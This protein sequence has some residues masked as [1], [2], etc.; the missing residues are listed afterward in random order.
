MEVD[1]TGDSTG[2]VGETRIAVHPLAIVHMS[3]Q[4][5]RIT[6]GGSP[7]DKTDPVVGLLFG[8]SEDQTTA[9]TGN[10]NNSNVHEGPL[11]QVLDAD[12]IPVE[13]SETSTM[14]VDLHKAVF[15][16]H[17]V[18][19]WYRAVAS[20]SDDE[21]IE[22]TSE[23]LGITKLL[24]NHYTSS[25]LES[26]CFCLLKVQKEN[27][28]DCQEPGDDAAM[29]TEDATTDTL[30]KELP[31]NLYELQKFNNN[32]VL[33]GLSNWQLDTSPAERIAVERVMKD[34][35]LDGLE[36]ESSQ[37]PSQNP[38]ILETK[39]IGHSLTSMNDRVEFLVAYLKDIQEGK[40]PVDHGILRQIQQIVGCLGPLSTLATCTNEGEEKDLQLLTHLAIVART[41]N[42]M[43]SYTEKFRVM[44]EHKTAS[45]ERQ[46]ASTFPSWNF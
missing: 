39:A 22:P 30:N 43:Q 35:P 25:D 21:E 1:S 10:L 40:T 46:Q 19:G 44:N 28:G 42:S 34:Q 26:F 41:V 23:D 24:K 4:Y 5:T 33:V 14:Q 8:L 18:V 27:K 3:D 7:M 45:F 31:I 17:K 15:P 37:S 6:S 16:K 9:T 32:T 36:S 13:V 29:K 11:I 20:H 38:F 12:D 2:V